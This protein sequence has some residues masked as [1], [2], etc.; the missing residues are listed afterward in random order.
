[1]VRKH[2][3][4]GWYENNK[5]AFHYTPRARHD[6]GHPRARLEVETKRE[7]FSMMNILNTGWKCNGNEDKY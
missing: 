7:R 4:N 5:Q 2:A 3:K 1:M 6:T